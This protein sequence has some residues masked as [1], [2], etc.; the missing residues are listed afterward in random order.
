M[1]EYEMETTFD[2]SVEVSRECD[3]IARIGSSPRPPHLV[4]T[5]SRS[6][7]AQAASVN[8][9]CHFVHYI[10]SFLES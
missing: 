9:I 5:P 7:A 8:T 6:P 3:E 4:F 2:V 1:R 10:P